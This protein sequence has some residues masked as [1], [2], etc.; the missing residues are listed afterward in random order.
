MAASISELE[1]VYQ[2]L[3]DEE[4]RYT[5]LNR[6]NYLVSGDSS[7]ID[8]IVERYLP[9]LPLWGGGR[10]T[11]EQFL[12]K[13]PA[14]RQIVLFGA[15]V[16]G[17]GALPIFQNDKRF[18]GFCSSTEE[19]QK[20]GFLGRPVMSPEELL[21][22][23]DLTVVI[24][25][26][27]A[28]QE[29]L[30]ILQEGGYPQEQ[31][32]NLDGL[33]TSYNDQYFGPDFIRYEPE[34]VFVDA[35]CCNLRSSLALRG[36]C[37]RVKKVYAF[38]PEPENYKVCLRNR[39]KYR[40][41]EVELLPFG[42][43]SERTTL[44]FSAGN[45]AVSRV[46]EAGDSSIQVM[47]IDE[48]V[49]PDERVTFLKMDIEGSELEALKGARHTIQKD[50]PKLAVCIYHKPED[51]TE[52]PLYIKSLVPEYRLYVRHHSNRYGETVLYAVMP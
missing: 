47:P 6:L 36:H 28:R 35:G 22:R 11:S 27:D 7:F 33:M 5:Y 34:E 49:D 19:K 20:N 43:W 38:E 48:A 41:P 18:L 42:V 37:G 17:R 21:S 51:M 13:L 29:I 2:I 52:I 44:H 12:S 39:E 10:M 32:F 40:F 16:S 24:S 26:A 31:V 30:K 25:A 9:N 14:D 23:K 1:R 3:E 15:G 50:R 4:S 45:A 46:S 8:R